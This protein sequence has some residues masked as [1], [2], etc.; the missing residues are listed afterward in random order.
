MCTPTCATVGHT[1]YTQG[2]ACNRAPVPLQDLE[3]CANQLV[4]KTQR[5]LRQPQETAQNKDT[6]IKL[7]TRNVQGAHGTLS[8]Q[9]WANILYSVKDCH[10]ELCGIQ[11]YDPGFPLPEA[12]TTALQNNYKCYAAP[13]TEVA[14]PP[15]CGGRLLPT[16]SSH[17]ASHPGFSG[18]PFYHSVCLL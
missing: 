3:A 18:T 11:K 12:A 15:H 14:R 8:L 10:I 2:R 4:T 1:G 9:S 16:R 6:D 17:G 13:G 7:A 5:D